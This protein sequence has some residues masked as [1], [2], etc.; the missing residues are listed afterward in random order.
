M[1]LQSI[2]ILIHVKKPKFKNEKF[3]IR[4]IQLKKKNNMIFY[5]MGGSAAAFIIIVLAYV[6]LSKKMQKSEYRKKYLPYLNQ[7][8]GLTASPERCITTYGTTQIK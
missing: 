4:K 8:N 7:L 1:K 2:H 3:Q 5:I 6:I